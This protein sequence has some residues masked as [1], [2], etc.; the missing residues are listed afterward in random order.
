M[1]I[2]P[3]IFRIIESAPLFEGVPRKLLFQQ[4]SESVLKNLKSKETLLSPGQTNDVVYIILSGRISIQLGKSDDEPVAMLGEGDCVGET[5][6]IGDV[7]VQAYFIAAT[8]CELIAIEHSA[9]WHLIDGSHQAARNALSVLSMR[10]RSSIPVAIQESEYNNEYSYSPI[11][12]ELTGLYNGKWIEE[13]I[14]RYLHRLAFNKEPCCLMMVEIDRFN[15]L[16][17][18][19]GQFGSEQVLRHTAH[20]MLLCLRP[21]DQAGHFLAERFAVFM[22]NTT[23]PNCCAAANRLI[24]MMSESA[25]VLPSGDALPPITISVGACLA[26]MEDTTKSLF[27]KAN[28]ALQHALINGGNCVKYSN[29]NE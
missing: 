20:T 3:E 4:V 19:Y 7:Q 28:D 21:D 10:I 29:D 25:V 2:T 9:M 8:D 16:S 23:L 26:N 12:D 22:P 24:K 6:I 15:E 14:D 27:A 13:K 18:K 5:S 17:D 11:I 1:T